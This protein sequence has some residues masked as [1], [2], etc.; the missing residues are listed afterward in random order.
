MTRDESNPKTEDHTQI[1][2]PAEGESLSDEELRNLLQLPSGDDILDYGNLSMIGIGGLG[3]VFSA[4]EPGL[5]REIALKVLRP[6]FRNRQ[7]HIESFIREARATAQIDH[8]NIVPVHRIG[9]FKDI[10]VYFTMKRIEGETL[11]SA[12]HKVADGTED[13][14]RRYNLRRRLEIF[15]AVCQGV[16]FAHSKGVIHRDLKPGNVMLG[17]Y[18]EVMIMD[19]G[20]AAYSRDRDQS[21]NGRKMALELIPGAEPE[22][23][24]PPNRISGTP[25]YMSPEQAR[26]E[27][28]DERSDIYS[29]GAILYSLLTLESAPYDP[30]KPTEDLLQ[31]VVIGRLVRPRR[32]APRLGIPRELEAITLKAMAR[33]KLDR[34]QTAPE[35]MREVRNYLDHYPVSA[36]SP[37]PFYRL[38]KLCVRRPLIPM[39]LLAALLSVGAV[40]LVTGIIHHI[41]SSSML[42]LA[43]YN[44]TQAD[45]YYNL[46][47]RTHRQIQLNPD[48]HASARQ[49]NE[50]AADYIRQSA[51][52]NNYCS[53]V[54]ESLSLTEHRAS[55][56]R[57]QHEKLMA[58]LAEVLDKQLKFYIATEN[59]DGLRTFLKRF[60]NRWRGVY[61][62]LW[63]R[64]PKL[65]ALARRI[66]NDEGVL[67]VTGPKEARLFI[68]RESEKINGAENGYSYEE[69]PATAPD[70]QLK[71][72][73]YLVKALFPD[74]D[75]I[76]Y[77]VVLRP[78]EDLPLEV[79]EPR[80]PKDFAVVPA[81]S[82]YSGETGNERLN[83]VMQPEFW[84]GKHEVT[85]GE[86]L[87]FW[88]NL[89]SES[90]RKAYMGK[91][92]MPDRTYID[93][94]D[95][96]GKLTPPLTPDLPVIGIPGVAAEA[97]CRYLTWKNGFN[98]RLPTAREWEKACRGVDGRSYPW[99]NE[100]SP[101][102][103]LL[104]NYPGKARYPFGAAPGSFPNDRSCY[105]VMD[106][107]G[108]VREFVRNRGEKT[109]LYLVMGGSVR[110]EGEALHDYLPGSSIYGEND[111]GFRVVIDPPGK[112]ESFAGE[113]EE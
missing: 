84:I 70:R 16:A 102:L 78:G 13:Y 83:K 68:R 25:A 28:L 112:K 50:L 21:T 96:N 45:A 15:S 33:D 6:E 26:G 20:L 65:A 95:Q 4:Q 94:W 54:L 100:F 40:Y 27:E 73:S 85:F 3:A 52:F 11:R 38:A 81:G 110:T 31:E 69:L 66:G 108:N 5:N 30:A 37:N 62:Q 97:Y 93:L 61:N 29:L 22:N 10:G 57:E 19:W 56:G 24:D 106:M 35:L 8:P 58:M 55:L 86:Y 89:Q 32:K 46:A 77:P 39:T 9:I 23:G 76:Y 1:F 49:R 101:E 44:L 34:Y 43:S 80:S 109:L 111:I 113:A 59:Y 90:D 98:H 2:G 12:I 51:E 103:A 91:Y 92:C 60:Q 82:F 18:G 75:D 79:E 71:S 53:A 105:G 87:E 14:R 41:Q 88:K 17:D 64:N 67:T 107:A 36:Y 63:E 48:S 72:G 47:L 99:G 42:E 7:R 74:E 104:T